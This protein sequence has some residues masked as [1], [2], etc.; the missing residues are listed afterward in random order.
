MGLGL[1][2]ELWFGVVVMVVAVVVVS[3]LSLGLQLWFGLGF[4]IVAGV[5]VSG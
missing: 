5:V 2:S 4:E 1:G 3:G